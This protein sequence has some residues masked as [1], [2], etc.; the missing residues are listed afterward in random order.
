VPVDL[1]SITG[2]ICH[3]GINVTNIESIHRNGNKYEI[4]INNTRERDKLIDQG[5]SFHGL[6]VNCTSTKQRGINILLIGVPPEVTN[7]MLLPYFQHYGKVRTF[8]SIIKKVRIGGKYHHIKNGN[9]AFIMS[10]FKEISPK[11]IKIHGHPVH[12]KFN[13]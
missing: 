11:S 3:A 8:Y 13:S 2:S 10:Y 5:F 4:Q 1:Q 7:E 12:C 9:R 6:Q